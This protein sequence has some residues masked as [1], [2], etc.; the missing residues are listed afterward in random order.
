MRPS[1]QQRNAFQCDLQVELTRLF[2][3]RATEHTLCLVRSYFT[4]WDYSADNMYD[5][6]LVLF[7]FKKMNAFVFPVFERHTGEHK[8]LPLYFSSQFSLEVNIKLSA[9]ENWTLFGLSLVDSTTECFIYLLYLKKDMVNFCPWFLLLSGWTDGDHSP[10]GPC[11][12]VY[13]S[14]WRHMSPPSCNERLCD[15]REHLWKSKHQLGEES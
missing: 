11:L 2:F 4:L 12:T 1:L 13:Q 3:I 8:K 7:F 14:E 6:W 5:C 9:G 10:V 15:I